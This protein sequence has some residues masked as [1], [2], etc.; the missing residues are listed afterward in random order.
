MKRVAMVLI[1]AATLA[2]GSILALKLVAAP[3]VQAESVCTSASFRGAF[4]YTFTGVTGVD[5][6][7]FAAVGKWIADGQGNFSGVET[8]SSGG[9]ILQRTY[10]G[11]YRVNSDCTGSAISN[12]NFGK[13]VK[14]D[15]VIV[16]GGTEIQVIETDLDTAVVGSLKQQ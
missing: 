11:T 7:A 3:K 6:L 2:G 5:A 10:T 15:F 16:S 13:T 8:A 9:E 14:C 12:D 4:G 1:L